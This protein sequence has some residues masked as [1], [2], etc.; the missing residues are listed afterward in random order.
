MN[1]AFC[2]SAGIQREV[3]CE[4]EEPSALSGLVAAGL[5][6]AFMPTCKGDEETQAYTL[7]PIASPDCHRA[8]SL[9]WLESRYLP[10]A[11]SWFREFL[12]EY[13]KESRA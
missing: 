6:V 8:F 13:F 11:A 10:Q 3:V 12:A 4:V 7:I 9:A 1:D 5:G 2:E